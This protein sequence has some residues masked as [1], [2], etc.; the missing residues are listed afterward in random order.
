MAIRIVVGFLLLIPLFIELFFADLLILT[1]TI[2]LISVLAIQEILGTTGFIKEKTLITYAMIFGGL[3]PVWVYFGYPNLP[4][5]GTLVIFVILLF[6]SGLNHRSEVNFEKISAA[7]F[8]ALIFPLFLSSV[9]RINSLE[10]GKYVVLLP[11]IAAFITDTFA[12]FGG[13]LFGKRKLAPDV[14]PK[15]TIEGSIFGTAAAVVVSV[16]YAFIVSAFFEFHFNIWLLMLCTLICSIVA[17]FGDLSMSFIKRSFK[18]KDFGAII[19]GHSG[20]L[21]RF[22]SLLFAAPVFEMMIIYL[23]LCVK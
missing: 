10:T 7:F 6:S 20:I 21:D 4:G 23:P 16:I 18:I 22:D 2:S 5:I 9:I 19:P 11:F 12:Y 15:K 1:L 3:V 13:R 14:S 17:Q 8:S